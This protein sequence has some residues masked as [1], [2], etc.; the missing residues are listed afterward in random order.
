MFLNEE[1]INLYEE[2]TELNET[3]SSVDDENFVDDE[4]AE[5]E[6]VY[7]T[8]RLGQKVNL[9]NPAEFEK[10]VNRQVT[11][12]KEYML[13]NLKNER[14]NKPLLREINKDFDGNQE[15][16]LEAR[17]AHYRELLQNSFIAVIDNE[18]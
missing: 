12:F 8:N 13:K 6:P 9:R 16:W 10:E 5:V 17:A 14:F 2:L 4:R 1:F 3:M 7:F 15:A 11:G 18:K